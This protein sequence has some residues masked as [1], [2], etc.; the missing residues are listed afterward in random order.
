[1]RPITTR[2]MWSVCVWLSNA[3]I[4]WK[5]A[6]VMDLKNY[7]LLVRVLSD[8]VNVNMEPQVLRSIAR[9]ILSGELTCSCPAYMQ[10]MIKQN[11]WHWK[12]S[13]SVATVICIGS[14]SY[15]AG[16]VTAC[17]LFG[18]CE[19]RLS[20]ARPLLSPQAVKS[21]QIYYCKRASCH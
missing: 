21:N 9:E 3:D 4:S 17:P 15:W 5:G 2:F 18:P 6:V 1:M 11:C 12:K 13:N 14:R 20:P 10:Q 19:P 8:G 16:Q 7:S